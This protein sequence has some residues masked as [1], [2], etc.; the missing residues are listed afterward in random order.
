MD[1]IIVIILISLI[2]SAFFSG[3]EIAF[4]RSDHLRIELRKKQNYFPSRIL[5]FFVNHPSKFITN[6]LIGN[7]IALVIYSIYFTLLYDRIFESES[8]SWLNNNYIAFIFKT[9]F[10]SII[11][12]MVA[13]FLPKSLFIINPNKFLHFLAVPYGFIYVLFYP[14]NLFVTGISRF[15]LFLMG[16]RIKDNKPRFTYYDLIN[17]VKEEEDEQGHEGELEVDTQILRNAIDLPNIKV[18]ECMVPR[19]EIQ[20]IEVNSSINELRKMFIESGHSKIIVYN[21]NIDNVIGFVHLIDLYENPSSITSI[22]RPIIIIAEAMP[23]NKLLKKFTESNRS[24]GL[25]VDEYGGTAG[26]V[27]IEDVLEEIFG[28]IDDEYDTEEFKEIFVNENHY[29]FS[30]RLETDYLNEKYNLSI[31]E[32]DYETL[33]GFILE[34]YQS[35]PKI[36]TRIV[37]EPFEFKILS[38]TGNRINE[39]EMRIISHNKK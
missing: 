27:T 5:S 35:I 12:L 10:S 28:E 30:S 7:N 22:V 6:T 4:Y 24:L 25:V 37:F 1:I 32:G 20:A 23:A 29:I 11:I 26:I 31:P 21:E 19:P 36:N 34:I 15:I 3:I 2:F 9:I 13:E 33:G 39:V 16:T 14:I 8:F 38:A 18:R 17:Y